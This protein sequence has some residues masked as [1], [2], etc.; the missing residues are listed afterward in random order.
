V[1]FFF[2]LDPLGTGVLLNL[3]KGATWAEVS[4]VIAMC[5]LAIGALAAGLQGWMF[6]RTN[7]LER[8][9]L[10]GG[11]ALLVLPLARI[12]VGGAF[13]PVHADYVGIGVIVLAGLI[14]LARR[15]R[16]AVAA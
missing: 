1:P 4:W 9:L 8:W 15:A 3:P 11:G 5:F 10:I 14:Q 13:L 6:T 12:G 16:G 2:V 7:K